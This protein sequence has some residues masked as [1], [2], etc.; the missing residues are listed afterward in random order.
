MYCS[1]KCRDDDQKRHAF[2]CDPYMVFMATSP[3]PSQ[4]HKLA[5]LL[6]ADKD[7]PQF[8]W[9][10]LEQNHNFETA[11][12][13]DLLGSDYARSL[14]GTI[15]NYLRASNLDM[16]RFRLDH[17]I[18]FHFRECCAAEGEV[19]N[20]C[21]AKITD[22]MT[23]CKGPINNMTR[24]QMLFTTCPKMVHG[25]LAHNY[26]D[27]R[28]PDF[29]VLVEFLK[30]FGPIAQR[31]GKDYQAVK[32]KP[33]D[34]VAISCLGDRILFDEPILTRFRVSRDHF[35]FRPICAARIPTPLTS[36]LGYGLRLWLQSN[37]YHHL[38]PEQDHVIHNDPHYSQVPDL[39]YLT[40]IIDPHNA[41]WGHV[42][43]P[44]LTKPS[45]A[46]LVRENWSAIT[47]FQLEGLIAYCRDVVTVAVKQ[48]MRETEFATPDLKIR[49]REALKE[50]YM[51]YGTFM[52]FFRAYEACQETWTPP[53]LL[54]A[55]SPVT[56]ESSLN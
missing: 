51:C 16:Q 18:N 37:E 56:P 17:D 28:V 44:I 35:I 6:P 38:T 24:L 48:L 45:K 55:P 50:Q 8:V 32:G 15:S 23:P 19:S 13:K 26:E 33:I 31:G 43:Q 39:E 2:V 14:E 1:S 54:D 20:Q 53:F 27:F 7:E 30:F 34:G 46:V 9:V 29:R 11:D 10:E 42:Y 49:C 5:L 25:C 52:E 41:S 21:I 4:F 36:A 22:S 3:R 12:L 47:P 40:M